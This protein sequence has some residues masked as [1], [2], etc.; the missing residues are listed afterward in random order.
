L[1]RAS[2]YRSNCIDYIE[3]TLSDA[4]AGRGGSSRLL[5]VRGQHLQ[6]PQRCNVIDEGAPIDHSIASSV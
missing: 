6:Q 1:D 2:K 5:S 3:S 4:G